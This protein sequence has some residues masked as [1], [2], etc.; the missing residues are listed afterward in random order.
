MG[1]IH[2]AKGLQKTKQQLPQKRDTAVSSLWTLSEWLVLGPMQT[3][4][5]HKLGPWFSCITSQP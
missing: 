3:T 4:H 5:A 1:L 2:S